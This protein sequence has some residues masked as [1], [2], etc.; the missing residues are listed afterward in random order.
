MELESTDTCLAGVRGMICFRITTL[1][2]TPAQLGKIYGQLE[3]QD[4][5]L[6]QHLS[7]VQMSNNSYSKNDHL[8][9]FE[10]DSSDGRGKH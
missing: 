7:S 2:T 4:Q 3:G 5:I 8:K 1:A 6:T 9:E 10:R